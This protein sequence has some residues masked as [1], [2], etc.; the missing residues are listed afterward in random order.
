MKKAE[1]FKKEAEVFGKKPL[2][3]ETE[4]ITEKAEVFI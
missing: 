4:V 1:V 2:K 3:K